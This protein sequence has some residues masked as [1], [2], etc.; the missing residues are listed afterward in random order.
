MVFEHENTHNWDT[1]R[2]FYRLY[3]WNALQKFVH[4]T[5]ICLKSCQITNIGRRNF[6]VVGHKFWFDLRCNVIYHNEK[7]RLDLFGQSTFI[8]CRPN[9][10]ITCW[11]GKKA[12][13]KKWGKWIIVWRRKISCVLCALCVFTFIH[14][15]GNISRIVG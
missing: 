1:W 3:W 5:K 2:I 6:S 12:S 7:Y 9:E 15:P 14:E 4:F 13:Y 11:N 8:I 10:D